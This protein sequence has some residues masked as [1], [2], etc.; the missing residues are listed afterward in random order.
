MLTCERPGDRPAHVH[1]LPHRAGALRLQRL[2]GRERQRAELDRGAARAGG[3]RG[4]AGGGTDAARLAR[5]PGERPA[6]GRRRPRAAALLP[7]REDAAARPPRERH[8]GRPRAPPRAAP[9]LA[10]RPRI[11]GLRL[12]PPHGRVRGDGLRREAAFWPAMAVPRAISGCRLPPMSWSGRSS[13]CSSIRAP[14]W[15]PPSL[16]AWARARSTTGRRSAATPGAIASSSPT[17][18]GPG[19]TATPTASIATSTAGWR[20]FIPSLADLPAA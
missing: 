16:R 20:R 7:R 1:R 5:R 15:A 8:A 18:A 3:S 6:A 2:H 9:H 12:P 19:P 4:R 13:G 10:R 14:A 11:G 17:P